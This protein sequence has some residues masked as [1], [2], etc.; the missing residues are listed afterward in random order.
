MHSDKSAENSL[1]CA[2]R[3]NLTGFWRRWRHSHHGATAIEYALIAAGIS[4][5][6]A[7]IVFLIGQ[8]VLTNMFQRLA[9]EIAAQNP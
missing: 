6:I 4:V 1:I 7:G 2:S 3:N 8:D 5:A 9:D